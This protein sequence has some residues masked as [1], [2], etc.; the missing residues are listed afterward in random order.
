[1]TQIIRQQK[2]KEKTT[3]TH[4]CS[5][6]LQTNINLKETAQHTFSQLFL[7]LLRTR[8]LLARCSIGTLFSFLKNK[9][10]SG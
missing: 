1:M 8:Q 2:T 7:S 4:T 6:A 5:H 10:L 3:K 9:K